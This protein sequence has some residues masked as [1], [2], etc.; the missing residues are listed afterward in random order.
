MSDKKLQNV[1]FVLTLVMDTNLNMG[2][3]M[4]TNTHA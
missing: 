1:G 4:D 3:H 2:I